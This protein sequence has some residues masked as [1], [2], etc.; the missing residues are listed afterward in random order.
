MFHSLF[1]K[2]LSFSK[3]YRPFT[4]PFSWKCIIN[5]FKYFI[6]NNFVSTVN[7]VLKDTL[8]RG[9]ALQTDRFKWSL[10]FF[11]YIVWLSLGGAP[12]WDKQLWPFSNGVCLK[13]QLFY[14]VLSFKLMH[15]LDILYF[16][17]FFFFQAMWYTE[18]AGIEGPAFGNV[19]T[20]KGLGIFCDSFDND[21]QVWWS[22]WQILLAASSFILKYPWFVD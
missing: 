7:Y 19:N 13:F 9:T 3:H 22:K 8:K 1:L 6:W 14:E 21:Q 11:D 5:Y 17:S 2:P 16:L 18:T 10:L 20:W 15:S 12:L 4:C